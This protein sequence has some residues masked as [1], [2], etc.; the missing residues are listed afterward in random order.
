M[1]KNGFL[2]R[3]FHSTSTEDGRGFAVLRKSEVF[4]LDRRY[5]T[6]KSKGFSVHTRR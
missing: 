2:R 5:R 3:N 1:K 4:H 6:L